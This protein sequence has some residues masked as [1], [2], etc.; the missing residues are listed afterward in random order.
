MAGDERGAREMLKHDP[1]VFGRAPKYLVQRAVWTRRREAVKLVLAL[2]F[3]PNEQE[4]NAP[5]M[6]TGVLSEDEEILRVLLEGGALLHLRD[7]W[8]D[9]T[10][11]GWADF[12]KM[13]CFTRPAVK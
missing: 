7:P 8:Y 11:I 2:G 3:D 9:S 4:D 6:N 1:G 10:G 5:I 13:H 12:F